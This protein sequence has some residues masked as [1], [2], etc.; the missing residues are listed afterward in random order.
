VA[1]ALA[2]KATGPDLSKKS[3][4]WLALNPQVRGNINIIDSSLTH[5]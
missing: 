3:K 1:K 5:H 2:V 4:I